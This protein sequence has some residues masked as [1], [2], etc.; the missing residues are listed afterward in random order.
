MVVFSVPCGMH[1][2]H[3]ASA[4]TS[5]QFSD[6]EPARTKLL[7]IAAAELLVAAGFMP[8]P[9]SEFRTRCEALIPLVE[10][11]SFARDTARPE[12]IDQHAVAVS[13]RGR[14]VRS[15]HAGVQCDVRRMRCATR[16]STG[17]AGSRA[18]DIRMRRP[19]PTALSLVS[20]Y[21]SSSSP[22]SGQSETPH[23][24]HCS[25]RCVTVAATSPLVGKPWSFAANADVAAP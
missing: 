16:A 2:R 24:G 12:A 13:R 9:L 8:K 11:G 1:Q 6:Q 20:T 23:S 5:A 3:C 22:T 18:F 14:L 19:M 7:D 15:L 10:L 17:A 21:P 4:G 25:A